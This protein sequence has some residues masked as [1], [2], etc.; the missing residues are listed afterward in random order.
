MSDKT[1]TRHEQLL[2]A[3]WHYDPATDRYRAP[4]S[5]SDGTARLHNLAAA[6][7]EFQAS[8]IDT[9]SEPTGSTPPRGTR[10]SDPRRQEPE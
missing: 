5:K 6:W 3:G 10:M 4:D 8:Q 1:Q 7:L 9:A 2:A